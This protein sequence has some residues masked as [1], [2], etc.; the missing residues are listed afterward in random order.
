MRETRERRCPSCRSPVITQSG[1]VFAMDGLVKSLYAC[2][3]CGSAFLYVRRAL[4]LGR[5]PRI[6]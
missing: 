3:M 2:E 1:K 6:D 5:D 4:D